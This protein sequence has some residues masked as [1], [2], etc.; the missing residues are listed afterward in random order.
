MSHSS[1]QELNDDEM[2]V[3]PTIT[4]VMEDSSNV[5]GASF[6]DNS[7][8][9][10]EGS[11]ELKDSG[12]DNNE[13][14]AG[15]GGQSIEEDDDETP[16]AAV[17]ATTIKNEAD[18]D[19]VETV[20]Q[21]DMEDESSHQEEEYDDA[22][23]DDDENDE[24]LVATT[25]MKYAQKKEG[26]KEPNKREK[27]SPSS[28]LSS[29]SSRRTS[30]RARKAPERTEDLNPD[31]RAELAY[32]MRMTHPDTFKPD[33]DG[34]KKKEEEK[35]L[36]FA[37]KMQEVNGELTM[38]L[39]A[40]PDAAS[41]SNSGF[42]LKK[43]K[44]TAPV[45]KEKKPPKEKKVKL[46]KEKK[47]RKKKDK[48]A[49]KRP[50]SAYNCFNADKRDMFKNDNEGI[51]FSELSKMVG[52]AWKAMD[53]TAKEKYEEMAAADKIRYEQEMEIYNDCLA[54]MEE[55]EDDEDDDGDEQ[56]S[57]KQVVE[58]T[59]KKKKLMVKA[60]VPPSTS[61]NADEEDGEDSGDEALAFS[62]VSSPS[63]KANHKTSDS[64]DNDR[65]EDDGVK[66]TSPSSPPGI[67]GGSNVGEVEV[68]KIK[69]TGSS[70]KANTE[71]L[72]LTPSSSSPDEEEANTKKSVSF[73]AKAKSAPKKDKSKSLLK[74][75]ADVSDC[76]RSISAQPI[77]KKSSMI[78]K[79]KP[80][81]SGF[82]V[83]KAVN[84][85]TAVGIKPDKK[86]KKFSPP[87]AKT[88]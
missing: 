38:Q 3:E 9:E 85:I 35:K 43:R 65:D 33:P 40:D 14:V 52:A 80:K 78:K 56:R 18:D 12:G 57:V 36:K 10:N 31:W 50:K 16:K 87:T 19:E 17:D 46:P 79:S 84:S 37:N 64:M 88:N 69:P 63:S 47:P 71:K 45:Q 54:E 82:S 1:K 51:D 25:K 49:P 73:D 41:T 42:G 70:T 76:A 22:A 68:A 59:P 62:S 72:P 60:I 61:N 67:E 28:S 44:K 75:G 11:E 13:G 32:V 86:K 15:I 2:D 20:R 7:N 34:V 4:S 27:T 26:A 55:D 83:P 81:H 24:I 77:E 74:T 29:S 21:E 53:A 5:E 58:P 39:P 8:E 48:N 23:A 6:D 66:D 30:G